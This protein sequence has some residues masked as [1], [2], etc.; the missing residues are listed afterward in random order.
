MDTDYKT[1]GENDS[2]ENTNLLEGNNTFN[3]NNR[4]KHENNNC[5]IGSMTFLNNLNRY[6]G[7]SVTIFTT[8]GGNS[9]SGFSG[10]LIAVNKYF[11]RLITKIGPAPASPI[12][13]SFSPE[14]ISE[15]CYD[16]YKLDDNCSENTDNNFGP[17]VDIP[18]DKIVAFVHD[19]L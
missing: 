8:S 16:P 7:K 13:N 17:M 12:N 18:I 19:A 3:P 14:N 5:S 10:V 6:I 2:V 4:N 9:G 15:N 1:V 11:I